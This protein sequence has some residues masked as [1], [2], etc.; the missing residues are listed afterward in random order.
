MP[1]PSHST[2]STQAVRRKQRGVAIVEFA[3]VALIFFTLLLGIMEFGRWL[4]TLGA[5]SEATRW[6]ARL[7]VVCGSDPL[8]IQGKVA[9]IYGGNGTLQI[10]Y[11]AS[12]C[13]TAE[14]MVTVNL[15]GATFTPLIPFLGG[16]Y[17]IPP[18]T[19]T[20]PRE[21]MKSAGNPV[22]P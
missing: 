22:C 17:A 19:T 15:V 3:F 18:F 12:D 21:Y 4:F 13:A 8:L 6:G 9:A 5:A 7:A 11:P 16:T 2:R 14:C 20:L 10:T 1:T